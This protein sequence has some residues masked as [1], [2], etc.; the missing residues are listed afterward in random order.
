MA[1][2]SKTGHF[3]ILIAGVIISFLVT[4]DLRKH[5]AELVRHLRSGN[6]EVMTDRNTVEKIVRAK[7]TDSAAWA[8][9]FVA[10]SGQSFPI[11]DASRRA[12]VR[13]LGQQ[14]L[15]ESPNLRF[16]SYS[17]SAVY[18]DFLSQA[19]L[20]LA[21]HTAPPEAGPLKLL[22]SE[23]AKHYIGPAPAINLSLYSRAQATLAK[24]PNTNSLK[25]ALKDYNDFGRGQS[26]DFPAFEIGSVPSDDAPGAWNTAAQTLAQS[27]KCRAKVSSRSD[28]THEIDA[29]VA[30]LPRLL[31]VSFD[32]PWISNVLLDEALAGRG[33]LISKYFAADGPLRLIPER[34]WVLMPEDAWLEPANEPDRAKL[35]E[36]GKDN[37]CC[38]V[39][40]PGTI[41]DLSSTSF[42]ENKDSTFTVRRSDQAPLLYSIVSRRRAI[43]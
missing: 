3:S 23:L 10:A 22:A 17:L 7:Y 28:P 11:D 19:L 36:W 38:R 34:F 27:G 9:N 4:T 29:N 21:V 15:A 40:C 35:R 43:P 18:G 26:A 2:L 20:E 30:F 33:P 13:L 42:R 6:W 31:E 25:K 14:T 24:L 5:T 41:A 16:N 1:I 12:T 37:T 39:T 32:R 8:I